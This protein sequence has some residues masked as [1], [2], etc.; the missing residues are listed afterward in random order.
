LEQEYVLWIRRFAVGDGREARAGKKRGR[1]RHD[2]VVPPGDFS[3]RLFAALVARLLDDED[4]LD[5]RRAPGAGDLPASRV[6]SLSR[7]GVEVDPPL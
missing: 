1:R 6:E 7:G 4:L 2:E 5:Y 3:P